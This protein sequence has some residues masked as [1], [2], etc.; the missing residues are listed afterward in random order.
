MAINGLELTRVLQRTLELDE[1]RLLA[2]SQ[3]CVA[4]FQNYSKCFGDALALGAFDFIVRTARYV[5][6][7]EVVIIRVMLSL[8]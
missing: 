4:V 2:N 7:C 6:L 1:L 8:K 3:Q 5:C